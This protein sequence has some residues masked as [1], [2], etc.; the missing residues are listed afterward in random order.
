MKSA[1]S[2]L[3]EELQQK[4]LPILAMNSWQERKRPEKYNSPE[5][6][7]TDPFGAILRPDSD[8]I[9]IVD[10]QFDKRGRA[11]F[12]ITIGTLPV[13]GL[14]SVIDSSMVPVEG[15]FAQNAT[16]AHVLRP[17][18]VIFDWFGFWPWQKKDELEAAKVVTSLISRWDEAERFLRDGKKGRHLKKWP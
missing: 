17:F 18:T 1:R 2:L 9:D 12:R 10:I 14:P 5:L 15:L 7:R 3:K 13:K 8:G 11:K 4:F 16:N 6:K